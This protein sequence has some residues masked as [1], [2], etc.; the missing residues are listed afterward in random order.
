VSIYWAV[1]SQQG[2]NIIISPLLVEEKQPTPP[3]ASPRRVA[4]LDWLL[5][6]VW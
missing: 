1:L 2:K 5:G 3:L 4:F 6:L